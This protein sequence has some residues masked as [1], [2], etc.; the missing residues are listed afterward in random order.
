MLG[1]PLSPCSRFARRVFGYT[2][3]SEI[4]SNSFRGT[5]YRVSHLERAYRPQFTRLTE[6]DLLSSGFSQLHLHKPIPLPQL[7]QVLPP[8][9][10]H[11]LSGVL[12]SPGIHYQANPLRDW[13]KK[14]NQP[15]EIDFDALPSFVPPSKDE[16]LAQIAIKHN[17]KFMGST[18]SLS[19]VLSQ[20]YI[21]FSKFK[22][23]N[24]SCLPSYRDSSPVQYCCYSVTPLD[25][26]R[27]GS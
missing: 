3:A 24:A 4:P 2:T 5:K 22:P 11:G 25:L 26:H 14:I 15:E 20:L 13:L 9:L 12:F 21:L 6:Q 19:G 17:S 7:N 27:L 8:L 18:S 16:N 23:T 10:S 1:Y